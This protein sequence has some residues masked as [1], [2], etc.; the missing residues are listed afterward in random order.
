MPFARHEGPELS[1]A[2]A[3]HEEAL[4]ALADAICDVF[5]EGQSDQRL[6]IAVRDEL[7]PM[8]EVTAVFS[9]KI[10]RKQ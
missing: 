9:S 7:G 5:L 4:G 10:L 2:E 1:G 8:I 3:A 6:A